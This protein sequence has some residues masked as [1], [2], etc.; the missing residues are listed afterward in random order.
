M[1]HELLPAGIATAEAVNELGD[2]TLLPEE[3]EALGNAV[4]ARRREFALGRTCARRAL[5]ALGYPPAAILRGPQREP[6]WP[7]GI[8]GSITHARGYC[9]VAVAR[10]SEFASIGIDAEVHATLPDGVLDQISSAEE[11]AHL[12]TLPRTGAHWDCLLFSAKESIYKAWF[13]LAGRWLGFE[14]VTL[15]FDPDT[16]SF[17]ARLHVEGPEV[18]RH[19]IRSFAGRYRVAP[20]HAL[21][22]VVVARI[23]DSTN[24]RTVELSNTSASRTSTPNLS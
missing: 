8:V 14:D 15:T 6:L 21:T 17:V 18:D 1:V 23:T 24:R 16:E 9:A 13:P 4:D 7:A 20:H 10:H 19:T 2:T 22:A 11:R 3:V 5:A 12:H